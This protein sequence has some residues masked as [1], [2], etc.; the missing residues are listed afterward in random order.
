MGRLHTN[1]LDG[2]VIGTWTL[3]KAMTEFLGNIKQDLRT[4]S[5][6][7]MVMEWNGCNGGGDTWNDGSKGACMIYRMSKRVI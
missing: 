4:P 6:N 3:G 2:I 5:F 1:F 7:K